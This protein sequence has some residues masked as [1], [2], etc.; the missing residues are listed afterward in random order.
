MDPTLPIL[1]H[2]DFSPF[3]EKIRLCLGLKGLA[4]HSVIAPSVMPKPDLLPLTGG[5]RHIPVLQVGA[6]VWCDTRCIAR[7]LDR[8]HPAPPLVEPATVGVSAAIEACTM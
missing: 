4:W 1:H 3:A 7:E 5:C 6:D 2:Y 8:R